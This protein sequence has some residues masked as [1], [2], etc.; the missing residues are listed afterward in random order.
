[1]PQPA[2]PDL[3]ALTERLAVRLDG[4]R[5]AGQDAPEAQRR[6]AFRNALDQELDGLDDAA[7]EQV[8][9]GVRA[10]LLREAAERERRLGEQEGRL[11]ELQARIDG[12]T[13]ERDRLARDNEELR[14]RPATA[15]APV[16]VAGEDAG[17][18]ALRQ[19]LARVAGKQKVKVEE[20]GFAES[21]ARLFR[22]V[23]TLM[24]FALDYEM[25]INWIVASIMAG[26]QRDPGTE[27]QKGLE[28]EA[29]RR[30]R[31]C[32]ED[33]SGSID[34]LGRALGRKIRF[35]IDLHD[36]FRPCAHQ[37]GQNLLAELEPQVILDKHAKKLMGFDYEKAWRELE[38]L[39]NDL[40]Q[41]ARADVWERFYFEAFKAK[42]A[43]H[44]PRQGGGAD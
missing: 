11:A 3:E 19:S 27:I 35:L 8:L 21:D 16:P 33:E 4:E 14:R 40:A 29:R 32:L 2:G 36:A 31:A 38:R 13:E 37:G 1:M 43:E 6:E 30:F 7:V 42:M 5:Q 41:L 18:A 23:Q 15:P 26:P 34:E 22:F 12:L 25:S 39:H 24:Q 44:L 17:F 10:R 20:L 28:F 9:A